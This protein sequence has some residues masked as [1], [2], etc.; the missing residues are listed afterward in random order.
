[1]TGDDQFRDLQRQFAKLSGQLDKLAGDRPALLF[2][3]YAQPYCAQKLLNP[4][5]RSATKASFANQVQKHL[6]PAFGHLALDKITNAEWLAW[7][8]SNPGITRFFNAR[9]TLVELL[10]AARS[11]GHIERMPKFDN[12]DIQ[13]NTG[14][15]LEDKEIYAIL[16]HS[17][18]PFRFIFYTFWKMGC[19][20]REILRWE[21]DMIRWAGPGKAW[22]D[23]P[24]RISKTDRSRSI[25]INSDVAALLW[26]RKE[27]GNGSRFVFPSRDSLERPQLSYQSAW[28]STLARAGISTATVYDFR[29]TFITRAAAAGK[30]LLYIAKHLDTSVGLIEK[31][32]AKSQADVMEDIVK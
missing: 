18:R 2:R 14:R 21:W 3:D 25:P 15:A 17:E 12:P 32:Y 31:T 20:P 10:T 22:I 16:R 28:K 4:T 13:R 1:M 23:I 11:E 9:K 27:R 26:R 29:R 19:R 5:L 8:M 7:V 6:V 24:A 30:P